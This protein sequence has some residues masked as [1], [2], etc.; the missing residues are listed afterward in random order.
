MAAIPYFIPVGD[1]IDLILTPQLMSR[2]GALLGASM[3]WRIPSYG[4]ISIKASGLYQLDKSAFAGTVGDRTW[5]GAIQTSGQVH[6]GGALDRR[7]VVLGRSPT[8]R[9]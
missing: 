4:S 1:D 7:L 8:R 5:R 6:S 3:N 9:I 2:Q